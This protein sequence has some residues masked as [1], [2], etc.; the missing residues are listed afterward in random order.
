MPPTSTIE[1]AQPPTPRPAE[2]QTPVHACFVSHSSTRVDIKTNSVPES[3]LIELLERHRINLCTA[4]P[5]P[6]NR[7]GGFAV[8]NVSAIFPDI[9]LYAKS[10]WTA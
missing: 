1:P 6:L 10:S 8:Q 7:H 5:I 3:A 2:L 9:G 4:T